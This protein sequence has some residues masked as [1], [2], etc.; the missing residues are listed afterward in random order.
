MDI[1]T[2]TKIGQCKKVTAP[3]KTWRNHPGDFDAAAHAAWHYAKRDNRRMVI[4][5]G[6]SYTR[7]VYHICTDDKDVKS[8][9]GP[10][11]RETTQVAVVT[12]EGE[13]WQAIAS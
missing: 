9:T 2:T 6:N 12:V 4:V 7:K 11:G 10:T 8:F 5:P 3:I 13:V 1:T